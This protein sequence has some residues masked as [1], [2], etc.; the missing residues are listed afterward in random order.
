[1][2]K[3]VTAQIAPATEEQLRVYLLVGRMAPPVNPKLFLFMVLRTLN[4][5]E[6]HKFPTGVTVATAGLGYVFDLL[7]IF[8]VAE[9]FHRQSVKLAGQLQQPDVVST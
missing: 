5:S 6:R 7:A 4:F 1:M 9:R 2:L 8:S 3:P